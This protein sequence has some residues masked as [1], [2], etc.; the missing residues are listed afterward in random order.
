[1]TRYFPGPSRF[2]IFTASLMLFA[3]CSAW[4]VASYELQT[5]VRRGDPVGDPQTSSAGAFFIGSLNNNGQLVFTTSSA[6]RGQLLVYYGDGQLTPIVV[7]GGAAPG[8]TWSGS[9]SIAG[10]VSMNDQ[11]DVV[12]AA[13]A[14]VG[15]ATSVGTFLW[16]STTKQVTALVLKGMPAVNNLTL[17]SGGTA[18][19][20]SAPA[21]NR[22]S[23][24]A[25]LA[26]VKVAGGSTRDGLF[27]LGREGTLQPIALPG[28]GLP[29]GGQ[30]D[31]VWLPSLND[32]GVVA[33]VAW[34][35][36]SY[37]DDRLCLWE[38]GTLTSLKAVTAKAL[39]VLHILAFTGVWVN[40]QNR[41]VLFAAHVHDL[42]GGY[43]ALYRFA[44][45]KVIPIAV[46]GQEMP[47]GGRFQTV[48]PQ[49]P[50]SADVRLAT[51]VSAAN[52]AG[53]HAFLATLE[54]RSTAA[55]LLEPDGKLSLILKSNTVTSQGKVLSVGRGAGKSQGIALNDKGQVAVALQLAGGVEEVALLTPAA[56]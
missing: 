39:G 10:P 18:D 21:I 29:G 47:G 1:V 3:S 8:G 46:P 19:A 35:P 17:A 15:G 49:D 20:G 40:D 48:Q 42:S 32:A 44:E 2:L 9:V 27:L 26:G 52:T 37:P 45:G 36:G 30:I 7:P 6:A 11:G 56:P 14:T 55:Y 22:R 4:G 38:S 54:D 24:I 43:S 41:N 34:P 5:I 28:G 53:Q 23:D 13:D 16:R 33:L 50:A 51:G 31:S 25:L 12:F